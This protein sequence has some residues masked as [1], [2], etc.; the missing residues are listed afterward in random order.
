MIGAKTKL[1]KLSSQELIDC[2]DPR[3]RKDGKKHVPDKVGCYKSTINQ[4]FRYIA[5]KGVRIEE[6]YPLSDPISRGSCKPRD[7]V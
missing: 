6:D 4:G 2:I 7:E 3:P 5:D 1:F